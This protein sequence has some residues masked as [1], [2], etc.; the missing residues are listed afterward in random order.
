MTKFYLKNLYKIN[1]YF[2]K[3]GF[4]IEE[5]DMT[6]A[7]TVSLMNSA[8]YNERFKAEYYQL[9]I[10]YNRLTVMLFAHIT[11]YDSLFVTPIVPVSLYEEQLKA[12]KKY[13][14]ILEERAKLE[15]IEL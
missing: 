4:K 15:K 10:H 6:L 9:K 2:Q 5:I 7:D 13:L 12:M 8:D 3:G 11:S 1:T 14:E